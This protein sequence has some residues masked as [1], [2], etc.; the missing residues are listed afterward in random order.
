ML[1]NPCMDKKTRASLNMQNTVTQLMDEYTDVVSADADLVASEA[2]RQVHLGRVRVAARKAFVQTPGTTANKEAEKTR[3]IRDI[4]K[5]IGRVEAWASRTGNATVAAALAT[6]FSTLNELPDGEVITALE[7]LM[8]TL[9][10]VI[11]Q[12][13][14]VPTATLDALD[15][16]ID[17]LAPMLGAVRDMV[18][19]RSGALAEVERER[20]AARLVLENQ[21]DKI[22]RSF[23]V[24]NPTTPI[25]QRQREFFD[26]WEK[27]RSIVDAAT[28][29]TPP[30]VNPPPAL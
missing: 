12:V 7:V 2:V 22:V 11:G 5:P 14:T 6:N 21:H 8:T 16:E 30:A 4:L 3:V 28:T 1:Q 18:V 9:R 13:T 10:G 15:E 29:P 17:A 27:A 24:A 19:D 26:R 20:K 25:Q 23:D